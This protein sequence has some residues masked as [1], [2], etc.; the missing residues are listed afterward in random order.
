MSVMSFGLTL[1]GSLLFFLVFLL[2]TLNI[3][4]LLWMLPS[5]MSLWKTKKGLVIFMGAAAK[6]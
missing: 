6:H 4:C 2:L 1:G 5:D 3:I